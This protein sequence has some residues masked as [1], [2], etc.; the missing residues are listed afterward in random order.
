M[1]KLFA[2]IK[3][4]YR[5]FVKKKSFLIGTILTPILMFAI[6]FLPSLFIDRETTDPIEFTIVDLGSGLVDAFKQSFVGKFEDGRDMYVINYISSTESGIE[7]LKEELNLKIDQDELGFYIV[8]PADI[9]ENGHAER[10]ASKHG[11]FASLEA[12]RHIISTVVTRERLSIYNVPAEE[13]N[14]LTRRVYIEYKRVGP[15]GEERGTGEFLTQYMSGIAFVMILFSSIL[16]YGQHLMRAVLEEKNSRIM[17]VLISSL[18]PFQLMMGKILGLGAAG[19]TQMLLWMIMGAVVINFGSG[20]TFMAGI[21]SNAEALS[22]SFFISFVGYFILGYFFYA[23]LFALL[24]SIASSERELQQ[25]VAPITMILI[26]PMMLA[27]A[28]MQNPDAGWITAISYI[29]FITPTLMIMRSAFGFIPTS[30]IIISMGVLLVS[31]FIMGWLSARIFRV[32]ILMYGKRP[33]L[34]E[35]VKWIRYK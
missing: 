26:M 33:T 1:N 20:S 9:V 12:I 7:S 3:R 22:L 28:V 4:E 27:I 8:V 10:Y 34:P 24:G 35:L 14:Q 25:F 16:G 31:V 13:V 15:E 17:E 32:G 5:E 11:N 23:T 6:I 18:S 2:V 29:P 21:I 19:L 30:Q